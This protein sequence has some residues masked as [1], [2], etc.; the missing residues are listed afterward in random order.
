MPSRRYPGYRP[1]MSSK[2]PAT[3]AAT[4]AVS[5]SSSS[6][7][8][9]SQ[10]S[11]HAQTLQRAGRKFFLSHKWGNQHQNHR[12]VLQIYEQLLALGLKSENVWIDQQELSGGD[13]LV[14]EITNAVVDSD[15]LILFI[16]RDYMEAYNA[17]KRSDLCWFELNTAIM[18]NIKIL[19]VLMDEGMKDVRTWTG[20]FEIFFRDTLH[21]DFSPAEI[22]SNSNALQQRCE[23]LLT[24]AVRMLENGG[25]VIVEQ[26][27]TFK[28]CPKCKTNRICEMF[29]RTER[30]AICTPCAM[31]ELR[32]D[33]P[34]VTIEE[35]VERLR[36]EN[37]EPTI[38]E[39]KSSLEDLEKFKKAFQDN[40]QTMKTQR[41]LTEA[42][43]TTTFDFVSLFIEH[44]H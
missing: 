26:N 30:S 5:S 36:K 19:P 14:T 41:T 39:L 22:Y 20:K 8:S 25:T 1:I 28:Y 34:K 9:S 15:I 24:C 37:H 35:E 40:I 21:L 17:D 6:S 16:T 3:T 7:S 38:S 18:K 12:K 27:G 11:A 33:H 2:T 42:E 43:I 23:S 4:S 29:D 32:K 44:F 10:P 13:S 31:S